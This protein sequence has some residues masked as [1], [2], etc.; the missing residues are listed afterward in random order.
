LIMYSEIV[1]LLTEKETFLITSH[2][3]PDGDSVGST[4]ALTHALKKT[5]KKAVPV[6][7]DIIPKMYSFLPGSSHIKMSVSDRYD[8]M[9]CLDCGDQDRLGFDKDLK[10]YAETII[11]I[12]HHK[13]NT[14]FGDYNFVDPNVSS[15]GELLYGII[16]QITDI[17]FDIALCLY[18]SIITD[19][20][21]ARY[22]NT[23]AS[24]LRM[25]ADMIE[26]GVK[27]EYVCKY[28]YENRTVESINLLAQSL[29]TI[30]FFNDGAIASIYITEQ[31]MKKTGALEEDAN[32]IINYAREIDGV[33]VAVL[34]REK[35]DSTI[36]VG[37]RSNDWVDVSK[38]AQSFNGGGHTRAAG[39]CLDTSLEH[40]KNQVINH[41]REFMSDQKNGH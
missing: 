7:N 18:T 17:N 10:K 16:E 15:A 26:L 29:D 9:I 1:Q 13:S 37:L 21:C 34:F 33:E 4:L 12:D 6:I 22:S 30:E 23:T 3:V 5:G 2:I 27:P 8:V 25:L 40:A 39:C 19:T 31:M 11:N 28:V 38:I 41:I 35:G 36:K 14:R 24:C 32:G 20:G